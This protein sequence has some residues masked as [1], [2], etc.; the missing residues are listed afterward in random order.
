MTVHCLTQLCIVA[1]VS[2]ALLCCE[3]GADSVIVCESSAATLMLLPIYVVNAGH[4][5]LSQPRSRQ[6]SVRLCS[7]ALSS[8]AFL[9]SCW[10][11]YVP[12]LCLGM[13]PFFVSCARHVQ[14]LVQQV[15]LWRSAQPCHP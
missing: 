8:E 12:E 15:K 11:R 13:P 6:P 3:A 5:R 10:E 9:S 4:L 14:G 2:M 1:V 7:A